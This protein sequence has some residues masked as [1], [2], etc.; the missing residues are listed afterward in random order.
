MFAYIRDE[1]IV[2]KWKIT[3]KEE[4]NEKLLSINDSYMMNLIFYEFEMVV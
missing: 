3:N 4:G 1:W 2:S